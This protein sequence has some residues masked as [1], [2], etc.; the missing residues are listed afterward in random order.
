MIQSK[1]TRMFNDNKATGNT[2]REL[3][4]EEVERVSGAHDWVFYMNTATA[5]IGLTLVLRG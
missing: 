1:E 2:M 5:I 4:P 3:K